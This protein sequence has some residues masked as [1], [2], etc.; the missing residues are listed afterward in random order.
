MQYVILEQRHF[1]HTRF[2]SCEE[3]I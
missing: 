1:F 3:Y 2:F